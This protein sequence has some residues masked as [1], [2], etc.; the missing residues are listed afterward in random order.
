[1]TKK[2]VDSQELFL[3]STTENVRT[4]KE[5]QYVMNEKL[6]TVNERA[7]KLTEDMTE[8]KED[9]GSLKVEVHEIHQEIGA[10]RDK[11]ISEIDKIKEHIGL[12]TSLNS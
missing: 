4:I 12:P 9:I 7:V 11:T 10:S 1:M 3:H 8:L 5:Q 6:D 2:K